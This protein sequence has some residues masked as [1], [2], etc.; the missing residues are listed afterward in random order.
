MEN[1]VLVAVDLS[2]DSLKAVDYLGGMLS[3]HSSATVT[4]LHVVKEPSPD[5]V[6]DERERKERIERARSEGLSLMEKAGQRLARHGIPESLI[7]LKVQVCHKA[8]SVADMILHEQRAGAY[9]TIVIGRRG[10][11]KREQF[12]FGS[13]STKVAREAKNCAVWIVG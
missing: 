4:L 7:R 6:P 9:G 2:E 8:V 10:L 1:K 3:C 5:I 13:V 11:S 12:L